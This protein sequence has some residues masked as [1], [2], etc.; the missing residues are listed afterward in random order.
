MLKPGPKLGSKNARTKRSRSSVDDDEEFASEFTP[1]LEK[2]KRHSKQ[3]VTA[4][5]RQQA[6]PTSPGSLSN[7]RDMQS[8]SFIIH[9][10]HEPTSP[11]DRIIE[12]PSQTFANGGSVIVSA[13]AAMRITPDVFMVLVENY[14]KTFMSFRLFPMS[15][16]WTH[17]GQIQDE[18][19]AKALLG[20]IAAFAVK[21][22]EP[23]E[24][25][26]ALNPLLANLS[27]SALITLARESADR[28]LTNCGDDTPSLHLLQALVLI[29]HWLLIQGVRGR[30]WRY[31]G[32]C[33]RVA[34]EM[35]L[36]LVDSGKPPEW[37]DDDPV[38]WAKDE[39]KRRAWWAIW[40]MDVFASVIRRCPTA[41]SWLQ[42]ET[43]LPAEDERWEQ[44]RPQQSCVLE[45]TTMSRCKALQL[46]RNQSP[47]A[48]FIVI[49]SIMKD[50][51]T[52]SSPTGVDRGMP[53]DA[54]N[55]QATAQYLAIPQQGDRIEETRKRLTTYY[56]GA[57][58]FALALPQCL[59]YRGQYLSFD[60]AAS[61]NGQGGMK[62][63]RELHT[64][65]YSIH[66]MSQLAFLMT[67]KYH[68]FKSTPPSATDESLDDQ[69]G[70]KFH[71]RHVPK[72]PTR[73][74]RDVDE[75]FEA[76]NAILHVTNR[77]NPELHRYVNPFL[78]NTI[79]LAAA[80]QLLK[81]ELFCATQT[82]KEL[83]TS[84]FEIL[85][86]SYDMF[87]EFW[88]S[89][90]TAKRNL[91][92]LQGQLQTFQVKH[93]NERKLAAAH[94]QPQSAP[95]NTPYMNTQPARQTGQRSIVPQATANSLA[96]EPSMNAPHYTDMT[97]TSQ[98]AWV[99]DGSSSNLSGMDLMQQLDAQ[100]FE[101][102]DPTFLDPF[103]MPNDFD[104]TTGMDPYNNFGDVFSGSVF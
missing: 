29:S 57:R 63:L 35:N 87:V 13:C 34:Y 6:T 14:F 91:V 80:V 96:Q 75:Y 88:R 70:A 15:R 86:M 8:L 5:T 3:A 94:V 31:L 73:N 101:L 37:V 95:E 30:A 103:N 25:Q 61:A 97:A 18:E 48:W 33:I 69:A 32:M 99:A 24:S 42:N 83:I 100:N 12:S 58:Y 44:Q 39:D 64:A 90:D 26:A 89:N 43:F 22:W 23:D 79:W 78:V 66:L 65:I 76:A 11:D 36:H 55:V 56:N 41:I 1:E 40:E 49:N 38:N 77:S 72:T 98:Q 53:L 7:N 54:T 28:A 19:Q 27:P 2:T 102:L 93:R 10:S 104:F 84:N 46:T 50:A 16:F 9:P 51:Q 85:R 62:M 45:L 21:L 4:D 82:E 20:A 81:R 59:K 52:T 17:L 47:R 60:R 71:G 68:L 74:Q 92:A 67:L